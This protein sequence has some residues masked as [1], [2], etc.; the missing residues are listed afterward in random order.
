[1][2][3]RTSTP[4]GHRLLKQWL[5]SPLYSVSDI[6][7]RQDAVEYFISHGDIAQKLSAGLQKVGSQVDLERATSRVWGYALQAERKA[8]M[9]DDVT[10]KRLADFMEL[11]QAYQQCLQLLVELKPAGSTTLPKR[12]TQISEASGPSG[13]LRELQKI[14]G[15]LSGSVVTEPHPKKEGVKQVKPCDGKDADYD[16]YNKEIATVQKQLQSELVALRKKHPSVA[17]DFIHRQP[18]YRYEVECDVKAFSEPMRKVYEQ[19]SESKT[20]ARFQTQRIKELVLALDRLEDKREDCIY[21]FISRLFMEFHSHQ[22]LFRAAV[23][24]FAELDV[25]LSL[26]A[27]SHGLA[28]DSCRAEFIE[29]DCGASSLELKG[30]R[31]PVAA[32]KMGTAFVPNDTYLNSAGVPG[33]LV[34][35]GPNMGGKSTVLRQ[36]CIAVVMAQLGM[37]V[38]AVSCKLIPFDRIFTR[39]GSYDAVL[40]GK[41]TL[42]TELEETATILTHGTTRSLAVLDELGRGTSTFDGAAIAAAVLDEL[43]AN[44]RCLTLFA[45]HYHP[46]SREAAQCPGV[47]PFHMAADVD[48]QTGE[49]TFLY[50]FLPGLCPSSHGHR[51]AQLAGLPRSVLTE[52]TAKSAEFERGGGMLA[53]DVG[54]ISRLASAGDEAGLRSL[55]HS[56]QAIAAGA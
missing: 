29:N 56:S 5:C 14:I 24:L 19:T 11:M 15:H 13:I 31:H 46:V 9:Y 39:I 28:G 12:L 32:S 17:L 54:E 2:G 1:M 43:M 50:R 6:R 27:A 3:D 38:N 34:V 8:V 30:C 49:M 16:T 7:E 42:L 25:L 26:A 51:V 21:P 40:E 48:G 35:T 37:H 53:S 55:F 20:K 10:A 23:R 45:T 44:V 52:A 33:V 36:T 18:G 41:S 22:A 4:F 47:A